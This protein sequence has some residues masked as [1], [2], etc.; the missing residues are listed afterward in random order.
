MVQIILAYYGTEHEYLHTCGGTKTDLVAEQRLPK[1]QARLMNDCVHSHIIYDGLPDPGQ[2][3]H[4]CLPILVCSPGT[5]MSC[6]RNFGSEI[7]GPPGQ[8]F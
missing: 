7:F 1:V 4:S 6:H 2:L 5:S 3:P 8:H